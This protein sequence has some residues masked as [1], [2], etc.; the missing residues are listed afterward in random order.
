M[1]DSKYISYTLI[2]VSRERYGIAEVGSRNVILQ[3]C[4]ECN[5]TFLSYTILF[6]KKR[7]FKDLF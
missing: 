5:I 3:P 1:M 7:Q 4:L 2:V 6:R